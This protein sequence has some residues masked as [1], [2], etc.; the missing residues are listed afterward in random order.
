MPAVDWLTWGLLRDGLT[1]VGGGPEGGGGLGQ[2]LVEDRV[3][4]IGQVDRRHRAPAWEPRER[5]TQ[6]VTPGHFL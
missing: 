2:T 6:G 1:S 4:V 5:R 3:R